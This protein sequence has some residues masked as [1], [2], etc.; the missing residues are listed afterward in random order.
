[1]A[2][3]KED[4][5]GW[6]CVCTA[7]VCGKNHQKTR[8]E[9]NLHQVIQYHPR[10]APATPTHLMRVSF[11]D[12]AADDEKLAEVPG[13]VSRVPRGRLEPREERGG[14]ESVHFNLRLRAII[15][16][17]LGAKDVSFHAVS[18]LVVRFRFIR[19]ISVRRLLFRCLLGRTTRAYPAS[20]T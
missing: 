16:R 11:N 8:T 1:M 13:D 4:R 9:E 5:T 15:S 7:D 19:P 18:T 6:M 2:K 12:G 3:K 14:L 10:N 20:H 17:Q